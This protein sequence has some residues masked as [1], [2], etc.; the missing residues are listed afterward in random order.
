MQMPVV[1]RPAKKKNGD[2]QLER[3]ICTESKIDCL[4]TYV[5]T[6][7]EPPLRDRGRL[8]L[9]NGTVY[10]QSRRKANGVWAATREVDKQTE[11]KW[12]SELSLSS[13]SLFF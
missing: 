5:C 10:R 8:R 2:E 11:M 12:E 6:R 1:M 4:L 3:G 13:S 7:L 9:S